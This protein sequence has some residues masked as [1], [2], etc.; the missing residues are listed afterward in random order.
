MKSGV[1]A[2][3]KADCRARGIDE[4]GSVWEKCGQRGLQAGLNQEAG[5]SRAFPR[6]RS[7]G[8]RLGGAGLEAT[9]GS[10]LRGSDL[11]AAPVFCKYHQ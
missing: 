1:K 8:Y 7:W 11:Q 6:L 4:E 10:I 5:A 3:V 2:D 9:L